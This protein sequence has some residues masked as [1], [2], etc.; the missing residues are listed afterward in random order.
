MDNYEMKGLRVRKFT[1]LGLALIMLISLLAACSKGPSQSSETRVL[2]IGV[3][4][5]GSDNEPYFRQQYT[6]MYE[7]NNPNV[8][9]EIVGAINYDDQR[10]EQR[11]PNTPYTQP[12]PYEKMKEMLTGQNPVDVVVLDYNMLRRF[13]QDNLLKPLDPLIQQDKF[14]LSDYVPTV[15]D[16]IK[17]VGDNNLYALTPTFT[18]SALFYNKKMFAESNVEPPTDKMEW[19]DVFNKARQISKGEGADRQF[20]FSFNRW[21]SDPFG[22]IQNYSRA[23]QLRMWD[24]NGDKMQ[25]NSDQWANVW[26]TVLGLHNEKIIPDQEFM[27]SMYEKQNETGVYDPFYGDLFIQ[28]KVGMMISEYYYINELKKAADNA[29][30][31]QDFE[32]VDWDVVTVPVDPSNPDVGGNIGLNQLM[33]INARAQNP[34]DAWDFIK[35]SN[36]REWAKLKSRSLYEMV[37]RKEFLKPIGGMQYNLDAFTTLKPF[38]PSNIDEDKVYREKPGV[39]DAQYA[40]NEL[41]QEVINGTKDTREALAEWET[42]GN[43]ALERTNESPGGDGGIGIMPMP[44]VEAM[45]EVAVEST[46]EE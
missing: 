39:W 44:K 31:I 34:D 12:D 4:Y 7:M 36:S 24:A 29:S 46:V 14:D 2:R 6:D 33:G 9:F 26:D 28:G 15:I 42:R 27:N 30:K 1:A 21:S 41:L 18:S 32:M 11:D 20:G 19:A 17:S 37:A 22:D 35:F 8:Q 43:A 13:T 38:P 45:E 16:G 5:G 10:F 3:L 40:G 23:L 25:V